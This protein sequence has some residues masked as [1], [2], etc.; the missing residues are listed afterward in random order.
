M[1]AARSAATGN[2]RS[3]KKYPL[4]TLDPENFIT[5]L[6]EIGGLSPYAEFK[7]D[8]KSKMLFALATEDGP[9]EDQEPDRPDFDGSGRQFE[10][11]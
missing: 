4:T 6:E 11:I 2:G 5:T 3:M 10:V 1:A 7:V 8:K 9:R